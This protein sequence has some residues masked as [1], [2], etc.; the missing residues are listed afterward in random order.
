MGIKNPFEGLH[1]WQ[2]YAALGGGVAVGGY[3]L[4]KHHS[5]TGSWSPFKASSPT[6]TG[7]TSDGTATSTDPITGLAYSDDSATDPITGQAYLAEAQQYGSVAAAEASVSAFGQSTATGSGIGVNPASPA[8]SGSINTPVGSSVYTSNAAWS[9]A[10]QAGLEDVSGSTSYDGTDIGTALGDY[11]T[12]QPL[13]AAQ[14]QVINIAIAEY[15]P[16]P[17][18]NL[19]VILAPTNVS[20]P[21]SPVPQNMKA[22]VHQKSAQVSWDLPGGTAGTKW[23]VKNT[24]PNGQVTDSF[25]TGNTIANIGGALVGGL[26][27]NTMYTCTVSATTGNAQAATVTYTTSK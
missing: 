15:G 20:A 3:A 17:V 12:Q 10:V 11:L 1:G 22:T 5:S 8:S 19:Q 24:G 27:A 7:T 2:I 16:A 26:K 14:G 21:L 6:T 18:G 4:Y 9:E 25:V 13:T 23:N